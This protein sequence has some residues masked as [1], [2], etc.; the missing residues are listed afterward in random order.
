MCHRT[1][2]ATTTNYQAQC[3]TRKGQ[4]WIFHDR[5]AI[6]GCGT[7]VGKKEG[8]GPLGKFFDVVLEDNWLGGS[9]F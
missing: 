8:E 2:M 1:K 7:V 4:T 6:I 5:P 3:V 9:S